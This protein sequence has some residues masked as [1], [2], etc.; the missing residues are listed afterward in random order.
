[1]RGR[2]HRRGGPGRRGHDRDEHGR[3]RRRHQARRQ[4]RPFDARSSSPSSA[5]SPAT[6]TTRSAPGTSPVHRTSTSE[7]EREELAE[8]GGLLIA[9]T[10][11]H[12]ARRIDNQLRGRSGRQ[13]HPGESR[14]FLSAEDDLVRLFAGNKIY[15][16]PDR[17]GTTDDEGNEE[18]I[19]AKMLSQADRE[20]PEGRSRSKTSSSAS[21]SSST[22]T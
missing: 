8:A 22:T 11:R 16:H 18:P 17:L 3:P 10:Q 20:G 1:M 9:G 14:F 7:R 2:D 19:E 5:S 15:S 13:G 12:E 4:R 21:A 6:R